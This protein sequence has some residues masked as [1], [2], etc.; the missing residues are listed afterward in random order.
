MKFDIEGGSDLNIM[1]TKV[2]KW[3]DWLK[4]KFQSQKKKEL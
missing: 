3:F 4:G 2:G 1:S